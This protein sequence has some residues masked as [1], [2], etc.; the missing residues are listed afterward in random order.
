MLRLFI[1]SLIGLTLISS[2]QI[3]ASAKYVTDSAYSNVCLGADGVDYN[4]MS[5]LEPS[6]QVK[7]KK[8]KKSGCMIVYVGGYDKTWLT[9]NGRWRWA[10]SDE[11]RVFKNSRSQQINGLKVVYP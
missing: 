4:A 10:T 9:Y 8:L 2:L 1:S 7:L 6:N 11:I 5:Q 3:P